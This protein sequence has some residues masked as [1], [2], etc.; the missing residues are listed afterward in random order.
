[1][2]GEQ[3]IEP[4]WYKLACRGMELGSVIVIFAGIV[5]IAANST[6]HAMAGHTTN[7][8]LGLKVAIGL[9]FAGVAAT[10]IA[11]ARARVHGRKVQRLDARVAELEE[12]NSLL[13]SGQPLPL[14]PKPPKRRRPPR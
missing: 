5:S 4:Y 14:D 9:S 10:I 2:A 7:V 11:L 8:S 6:A 12:E 3:E 13:R 1:M